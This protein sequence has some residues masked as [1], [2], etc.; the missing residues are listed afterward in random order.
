MACARLLTP[1]NQS[2]L[3]YATKDRNGSRCQRGGIQCGSSVATMPMVEVC[4]WIQEA[5]KAGL[6]T[7]AHMSWTMTGRRV[8]KRSRHIISL[9]PTVVTVR[10]ITFCPQAP[11][12]Q[13][14]IV[15]TLRPRI[16]QGLCHVLQHM[17]ISL[18]H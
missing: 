7:S 1:T 8:H 18:M 6:L 15:I 17:L 14:H 16:R 4:T 10:L 11:I 5:Q 12:C 3:T 13:G 9:R 2:F